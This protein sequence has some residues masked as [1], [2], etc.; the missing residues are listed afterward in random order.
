MSEETQFPWREEQEAITTIC[1]ALEPLSIEG[2]SRVVD[3]I[4]KALEIDAV[5]PSSMGS[6]GDHENAE[7]VISQ[8]GVSD[9]MGQFNTLA[10]LYDR[11][12]PATESESAL[13]V[14]YWVQQNNEQD[15]FVS[16]KVNKELKHLGRGINNITSALNKM[17]DSDPAL[18]MQVRKSGSSKQARK[19]YKI[20]DAGMKSVKEM[21][22]G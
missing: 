7:E 22:S 11:A 21:I 19:I 20:T 6:G 16:Q 9:K 5:K 8:E 15:T 1:E 14:A 10:D 3:Y 4:I 13:V 12:A 18:I 2:R 17:M